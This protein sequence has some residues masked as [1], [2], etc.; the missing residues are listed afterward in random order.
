MVTDW[1][2]YGAWALS[3]LSA[4][5]GLVNAYS[6][7]APRQDWRPLTEF[8]RKGMRQNHEIRELYFLKNDR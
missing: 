8:E 4:V 6:G 5:P 1:E 2:D 3:E 7:Y